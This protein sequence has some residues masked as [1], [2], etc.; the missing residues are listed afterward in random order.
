VLAP[1]AS[2]AEA[3]AFALLEFPYGDSASWQRPRA[4]VYA[5]ATPAVLGWEVIVNG[6]TLE[7]NDSHLHMIISP[8]AT[9]L[10]ESYDDVI[11][12]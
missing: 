6:R 1:K 3:L 12:N 11:V 8:D 10:L 9:R 4:I 5:R 2:T 7:G